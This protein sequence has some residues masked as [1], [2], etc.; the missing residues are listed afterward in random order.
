MHARADIAWPDLIVGLYDLVLAV[1]HVE[2]RAWLLASGY[3]ETTPQRGASG[4]RRASAGRVN[5]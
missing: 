5:G 3:P 2:G 1:D 4:P